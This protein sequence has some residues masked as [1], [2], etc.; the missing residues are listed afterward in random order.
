[1]SNKQPSRAI[2]IALWIAQILLAASMVWA[3][4]MKLFSPIDKLSAM[5]PWTAQVPVWLVK[6]TGVIDM[7]G[8]AGLILPAL[9]R[10]KPVLTPIAA[11]CIIVLMVCASV[12]HI[13]S[14]EAS[15]IGVNIVFAVL[16]AFIAWGR[17]RE[18]RNPNP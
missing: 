2:N 17:F 3:A 5:W 12:F 18:A 7:L 6:F 16:A 13:S 8:A 15:V 1:M 4:S 9:L 14:G 10:I 11:I